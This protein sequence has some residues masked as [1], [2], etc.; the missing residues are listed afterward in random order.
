MYVLNYMKQ[1]ETAAN[2]I[3]RAISSIYEGTI[4]SSAL[5][6]TLYFDDND[7]KNT[8]YGFRLR[9]VIPTRL[10]ARLHEDGK[11]T[12]IDMIWMVDDSKIESNEFVTFLPKSSKINVSTDSK[13][14]LNQLLS[15]ATIDAC[16]PDLLLNRKFLGTVMLGDRDKFP[17]KLRK[18]L[19]LKISNTPTNLCA[20]SRVELDNKELKNE[21]YQENI[22][23]AFL[24][25]IDLIHRTFE[26]L[27][28][29]QQKSDDSMI[30]CVRCGHGLPSD[31][32]YCPLCGSK[33]N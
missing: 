12:I 2:I 27:S 22:L 25:L 29:V 8:F 26:I 28:S 14:F 10:I 5:Y 20:F 15:D 19:Q 16:Y 24:A 17:S 4:S 13:S 11:S 33:Q 23:N 6:P 21:N 1:M 32:Y 30:Y 3:F 31:S 9:E 7:K 18:E